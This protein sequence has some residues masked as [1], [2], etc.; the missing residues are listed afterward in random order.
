MSGIE[1][2]ELI[3]D[4]RR[5]VSVIMLSAY[6]KDAVVEG[7]LWGAKAFVCKDVDGAQ[8]KQAIRRVARG[9]TVLDPKV[10]GQIRDWAAH[11]RLRPPTRVLSAQ[12]T[13]V[14]RLVARGWSNQRI[15]GDM[16][17]AVNTVKNYLGRA[18]A[19]LDC[20]S[21]VEGG[22]AASRRGLL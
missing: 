20:R 14:I 15:A 2:R 12:E 9:E 5:E 21:W 8:L 6:L 22:V 13:R 1:L 10:A 18:L 11:P 16:G 17:I 3:G 7:A 19:K 4:R